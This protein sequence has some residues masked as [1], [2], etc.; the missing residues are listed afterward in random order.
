MKTILA[1]FTSEKITDEDVVSIAKKYS[2]NTE[3]EVKTGDFLKTGAYNKH[4]QVAEV[5]DDPFEFVIIPGG[6]LTNRYVKNA[7]PI[8]VLDD[9]EILEV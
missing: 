7:V 2:F 9:I 3:A 4:L 1:I 5:L 6:K 8:K